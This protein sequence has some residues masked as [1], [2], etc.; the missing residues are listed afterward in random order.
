M[1]QISLSH[2]VDLP[3]TPG[4]AWAVIADYARDPEW[5]TGVISMTAKPSGAVDVGTV[6]VEELRFGGKSYS[7]VGE[8]VAVETGRMLE[9]RTTDGA[10]A[11]GRRSVTPRSDGGCRVTLELN[12]RPT[13][14]ERLL[15]PILTRML[16]RN[17]RS[18]LARL[19]KTLE[20]DATQSRHDLAIRGGRP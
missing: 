10:D 3:V 4:A 14:I 13:G 2:S 19:G 15:A 16:A 9:W 6:T 17:L 1:K 8:V 18:D 5:R 20:G 7:N 12:V 11:D